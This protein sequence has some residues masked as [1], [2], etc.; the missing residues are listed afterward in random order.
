MNIRRIQTTSIAMACCGGVLLLAGCGLLPSMPSLSLGLTP[1][2]PV[3]AEIAAAP[4][5]KLALIGSA[6]GVQIYRCDVKAATPNVYEWA[7]QAS[8]AMLRDPFGRY[9]GKH[10]LGPT[11]EAEDGSKVIG[12]VD[13]RRDASNGSI[14]WLRLKTRS[15]GG[16]GTL[17][18]VTTVLRVATTGGVPQAAL[19]NELERGRITRIEYTADYYFYAKRGDEKR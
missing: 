19:C 2:V 9:L 14:P 3:P 5:E 15:T 11:W 13:A 8:E 1:R 7:L 10:Y 4:D 12:S 18:G 6:T 17:N 16:A